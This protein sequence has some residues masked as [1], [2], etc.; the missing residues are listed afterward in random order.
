MIADGSGK[1]LV[2]LA[3]L[4]LIL[5]IVTGGALGASKEHRVTPAEGVAT[6]IYVDGPDAPPLLELLASHPIS[7]G[8][9]MTVLGTYAP[10]Q[11]EAVMQRTEAL[12]DQAIAAGVEPRVIVQP[13][14]ETRVIA[15]LAHDADP[16]LARGLQIHGE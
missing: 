12:A 7:A 9:Q 4:S 6:A 13:A 10:G 14:A 15:R 5:F 8:E 1:W 3:D 2:P 11:R 16:G